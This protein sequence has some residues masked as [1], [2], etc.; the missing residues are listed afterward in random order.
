MRLRVFL[1]GGAPAPR[2]CQLTP[3]S[4]ANWPSKE[5]SPNQAPEACA[6]KP[7]AMARGFRDAFRLEA[8]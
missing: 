3:H 1:P 2:R 6:A 4:L 8:G 5:L 7:Q